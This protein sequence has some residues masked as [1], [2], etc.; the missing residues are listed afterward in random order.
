MRPPPKPPDRVAGTFDYLIVGAGTAG[1]V[2]AERLSADP[3]KRVLLLEA[4]PPDRHP[5]IHIP[6]GIAKILSDPAHVWPFTAA[7]GMGDNRP[8]EYWLRGK[9]L[10]GSSSTNG[11]MYVRPQP[12]DFD[13]LADAAGERWSWTHMAPI[14]K[15]IE[16]HPLGEAET[17]GVGGPLRLSLPPR[18]P[19]MDGLIAAGEALGLEPVA[20][21]NDPGD[22][23]RI[24]YCPATIRRGR[25]QSAARAFLRP[26]RGRLNLKIRT[27]VIV[28][29]VVFDGTRAV[30]VEVIVAGERERIAAHP[31]DPGRRHARF[32]GNSSTIW[33]RR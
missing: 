24:G 20:D 10:G 28:D 21:V 11:M 16:D 14:F 18:H 13:D 32:A 6:R 9:V 29:R 1:C 3:T 8:P 33:N 4:G 30:G 19:L 25:R 27:G 12:A 31:G 7:R 17:R 2:L 15:A 22:H 26:A 23:P 5:M